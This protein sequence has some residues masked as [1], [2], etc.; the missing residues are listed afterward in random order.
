VNLNC[1]GLSREFL[2]TELFGH[3]KGA[4]TGATAAKP[5]LLEVAHRGSAFLD[6]IGDMDLAVQPK[7]LKVLE[8]KRFRRLGEV[9]DRHVDIRLIAATHRDLSALARE[10]LFRSDLYYRISTVP[11]T[12]PPLRERAGDVPL[13]ARSLLASLAHE[14]GRAVPALAPE[15]E[16]ALAAYPWPGN[17]REL[18]NV[19]E[20]AL[21]LRDGASL[22]PQ[23]LRFDAAARSAAPACGA[24]LTLRD[25]ER[26]HIERVLADENGHVERAAVRLGIPRSTLYQKIK[27]LRLAQTP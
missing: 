25:L 16:R 9:R 24:D 5:G 18:R 3:E 17:V 21:I 7:V 19:L 14:M 2:D 6:E 1:A 4:F 12:I 20:R 22:S 23:D 26:L 10:G 27:Q 15:T 11:L 8:E 13:I